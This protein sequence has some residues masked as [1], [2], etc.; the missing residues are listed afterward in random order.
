MSV[1]C[2]FHCK[3]IYIV[4]HKEVPDTMLFLVLLL[5]TFVMTCLVSNRDKNMQDLEC[6]HELNRMEYHHVYPVSE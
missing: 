6:L 4:P 2:R 1:S 5:F 3:L